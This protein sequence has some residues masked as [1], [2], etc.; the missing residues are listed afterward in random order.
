[1]VTGTSNT[2]VTWELPMPGSGSITQFGV[3]T[4]PASIPADGTVYSVVA[5]SL[6]DPTQTA[7]VSVAVHLPIV[8]A[9]SWTNVPLKGTCTFTATTNN[10]AS[11]SVT[12]SCTGGTIDVNGNYTAPSVSGIY[13]VTAT[14]VSDPSKMGVAQVYVPLVVTIQPTAAGIFTGTS[15]G[16]TSQV[17]GANDSSVT[18]S[19]LEPLSG[20]ITQGGVYQAPAFSGLFHVNA[21]SQVDPRAGAQAAVT[22]VP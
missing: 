10:L 5:R 17:V 14:S 22:V 1:M 9:P 7:T 20:T 2:A 3:Y 4:A 18:W 12:W 19:I 21:L 15:V 8:V 11:H 16:F 13:V 6:A